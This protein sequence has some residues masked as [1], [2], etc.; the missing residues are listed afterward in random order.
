MQRS[1][2]ARPEAG[3]VLGALPRVQVIHHALQ[4]LVGGGRMVV[5]V[6]VQVVELSVILVG[7]VV[8]LRV[9]ERRGEDGSAEVE[10]AA[11]SGVLRKGAAGGA[12]ERV[13]GGRVPA[14]EVVRDRTLSGG[15]VRQGA[16]AESEVGR[17]GVPWDE[18]SA[19]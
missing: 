4:I 1:L 11:G 6:V 5:V 7:G 14:E 13:G 12:R 16:R 8:Q 10:V 17:P 18:E 19:V 15:G 3:L 2:N 9:E